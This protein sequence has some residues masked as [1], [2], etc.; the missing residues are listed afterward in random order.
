AGGAPTSCPLSCTVTEG[1]CYDS[2]SVEI[3]DISYGYDGLPMAM[4]LQIVDDTCKPVSGAVVDV[5]HVSPVGKYSGD[6]S[7]NEDV[8]FCTG[9]DTD[10]TSHLYF[11]GKQTTDAD[12]L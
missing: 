3:Q 7:A 6:D 9:N 11:R 12:G 8:A 10:F 2:A 5:W 1:P 4:V